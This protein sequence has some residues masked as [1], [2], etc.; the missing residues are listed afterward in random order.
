MNTLLN[1]SPTAVVVG[2]FAGSVW[3]PGLFKFSILVS[4]ILLLNV[5]LKCASKKILYSKHESLPVLGRGMRPE[6]QRK[7]SP[8]E[9]GMPSGHAHF[10]FFCLGYYVYSTQDYG[11]VSVALLAFAVMVAASRVWQRFHTVRQVVVG[12]LLGCVTGPLVAWLF[13]A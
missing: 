13:S 4:C 9:F 10:A 8:M 11:P 6:E 3:Y 2:G 1:H 12:G 7:E 5:A